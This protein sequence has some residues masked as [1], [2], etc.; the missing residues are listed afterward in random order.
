[1]YPG[2]ERT[3]DIQKAS[4][5]GLICCRGRI[6]V[7]YSWG[8]FHIDRQST[9]QQLLHSVPAHACAKSSRQSVHRLYSQQARFRQTLTFTFTCSMLAECMYMF[10]LSST[11]MRL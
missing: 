4:G 1:M 8:W 6:S 2:I 5:C 7:G 10:V 3:V 9:V 11:A